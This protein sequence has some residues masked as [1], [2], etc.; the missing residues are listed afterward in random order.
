MRS[1][2]DLMNG[3]KLKLLSP[4]PAPREALEEGSQVSVG[5]H[6]PAV[7]RDNGQPLRPALTSSEPPLQRG[8]LGGDGHPAAVW[9]ISWSLTLAGHGQGRPPLPLSQNMGTAIRA[10]QMEWEVER[11]AQLGGVGVGVRCPCGA[12]RTFV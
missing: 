9:R 4:P 11:G 3:G 10:A 5:P 12:G 2:P 6:T 8:P 7:L 1:L